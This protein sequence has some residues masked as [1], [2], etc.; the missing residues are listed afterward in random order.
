MQALL[1]CEENIATQ[2]SISNRIWDSDSVVVGGVS[3]E[4][5]DFLHLLLD[6]D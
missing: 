4:D 1:K 3:N 2:I 6:V 5:D